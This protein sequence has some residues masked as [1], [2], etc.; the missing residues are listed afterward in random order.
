MF[1][2]LLLFINLLFFSFSFGTVLFT[3][4][5][6]ENISIVV[7]QLEYCEIY[8]RDIIKDSDPFYLKPGGS[9]VVQTRQLSNGPEVIINGFEGQFK[10]CFHEIKLKV[11]QREFS[12]EIDCSQIEQQL[13]F[14]IIIKDQDLELSSFC[15]KEVECKNGFQALIK[16]TIK[17]CMLKICCEKKALIKP[18]SRIK[19]RSCLKISDSKDQ[20]LPKKRKIK[21]LALD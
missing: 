9:L 6:D 12:W 1:K 4:A 5:S 11:R 21:K 16:Q 17:P 3:N 18:R 15:Y 19:R 20:I 10:D 2:Q 8:N 14:D 7:R 13:G